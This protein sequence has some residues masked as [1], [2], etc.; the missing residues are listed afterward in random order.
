MCATPPPA[1][2]SSW[3]PQE[4]GSLLCPPSSPP[5]EGALFPCLSTCLYTLGALPSVDGQCCYR[6]HQSFC[7]GRL[8]VIGTP[9]QAPL[10]SGVWG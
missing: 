10:R 3:G 9:R 2:G 8:L 6:V 4:D 1:P 7:C 5:H